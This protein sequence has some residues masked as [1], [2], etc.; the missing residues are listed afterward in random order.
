[1]QM[2]LLTAQLASTGCRKREGEA[3][4]TIQTRACTS[5]LKPLPITSLKDYAMNAAFKDHR[6]PPM[7][8]RGLQYSVRSSGPLFTLAE[9]GRGSERCAAP[10]GESSVDLI[11]RAYRARTDCSS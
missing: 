1:M 2:T 7:Q 5:C 4:D 3:I 11:S 9:T 6:F 10:R 8:E